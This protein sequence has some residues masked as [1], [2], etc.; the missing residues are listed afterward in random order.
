MS[1]LEIFR[2]CIFHT[3]RN[4]FFES[5]GLE[6]YPDGGLAVRDG[7]IEDCGDFS[8]VRPKFPDAAVRDL[9]GGYL[10]PGLIDT[11]IHL[12]QTRVLGSFGYPVLEWLD[13]FTLPE[14]ARFAGRAYAA[15]RSAEF[16]RLLA[17]HGTT[18]ALVFGSH[19]HTA[20]SAFFEAAASSGLRIFAGLTLSDRRLQRSLHQ[21]PEAAYRDAS[22]LIRRFHGHGRL[23]YAVMPRFAF[24]TS[25]AMLAVCQTLLREHP[26]A[27]FTTHINESPVEIEE[28]A[29]LFPWSKSYLGVY[30]RFDLIGR[31]SVLAHNVHPTDDELRC[32]ATR[33]ASVAHCPCSNAALGSGILPL[34]RHLQHRVRVALGTDVGA[35][36]GFG[37]LK[38]G[39]QAYSLQMIAP[40]P[41]SLTAGQLL[42]MATR[43]GAEALAID[44]ETGDFSQG[45]A[46][47]FVYLK[48]PP[49][50]ALA[51]AIERS[52]DAERVLAAIFTLAQPDSIADVRVAGSSVHSKIA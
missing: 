32:I 19:F 12:P 30:E 5:H 27:A 26:D 40:E 36:T 48:P 7:A 52:E 21:T 14:E 41:M 29:K 15:E 11:H 6:A 44:A 8:T 1:K 51:A 35:G 17:A 20:M 28:V 13:R 37:M 38:E 42:Y 23:R 9:R 24:S 39:L 34:Q 3:P 50:S 43:A 10:I 25:E 2:A 49:E 47:D 16:L 46:A 18:T 31:R 33:Q 22:N 45:K 4:P